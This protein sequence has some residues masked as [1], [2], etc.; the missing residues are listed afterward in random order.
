MS[1]TCKHTCQLFQTYM[2]WHEIPVYN[3]QII[4]E[5]VNS[6]HVREVV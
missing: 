5:G 2:F 6:P 1:D 4:S 3:N